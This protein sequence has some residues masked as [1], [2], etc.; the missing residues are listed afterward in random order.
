MQRALR[1]SL[2]V[3]LPAALALAADGKP[4][5]MDEMQVA[6]VK[7]AKWM[8][9][10]APEIPPGAMGSPIAADPAPGGSIGYAK[11]APGYAFPMH[12]HSATEFT[13]IVSG[14]LKFTVD[15]KAYDLQP[16]SYIV[17]PAKAHHK[18]TCGPA[19]ECVL[20]TRRAGPTDYNWVK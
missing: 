8:A 17:I 12:W 18:V 15:G 2:L 4:P 20:L 10:K 6:N 19:S 9:P 7:D 11:F 5:T 3:V 1:L 13:S 16:G 14:T